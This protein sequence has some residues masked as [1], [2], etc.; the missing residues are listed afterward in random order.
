M[1]PGDGCDEVRPGG[2]GQPLRLGVLGLLVLLPIS[3]SVSPLSLTG[4]IAPHVLA[5]GSWT[6]PPLRGSLEHLYFAGL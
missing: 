6:H 5:V 2:P 1:M 3:P 4:L